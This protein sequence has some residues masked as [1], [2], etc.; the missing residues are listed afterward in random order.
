MIKYPKINSVFK[1]DDYG[2]FTDEFS[3]EEIRFLKDNPWIGSEKID[4]MNIRIGYKN[5]K[6]EIAGKTE[7]SRIP[8]D[9]LEVL[10][11]YVDSWK[12]HEFF[13]TDKE[14]V[15]F[16]EGY[17]GKIQGNPYKRPTS[18]LVFDIWINGWWLK[19][20]DIVKICNTIDIYT[21]K[22][23][24]FFYKN[25]FEAIEIVKAGAC[26]LC[27]DCRAEGLVL[28]PKV[29]LQDRMGN[30]IITKIKTKD[31]K[32]ADLPKKVLRCPNCKSTYDVGNFW[33]CE[34]CGHRWT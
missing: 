12:G 20:Y 21:I 18:F 22:A 9:L 3:M 2:K 16:G 26:S 27:G 7:K 29:P 30:R 10:Q 5:G 34:R 25:I 4:G 15:I 24:A 28:E 1:R 11:G 23:F 17:G 19:G 32:S 6:F 33:V 8:G 14:I 13:D 31:F